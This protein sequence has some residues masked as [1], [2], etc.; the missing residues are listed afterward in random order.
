[1]NIIIKEGSNSEQF[2]ISGL[3]DYSNA[4]FAPLLFELGISMAYLMMRRDNPAVYVKP[5]LQGYLSVIHLSKYAMDVLFY[6]I[7]GR[8]AQSYLNG[9]SLNNDN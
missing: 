9:K 5:F 4:V 3:I 6:V 8:L 1:M 2:N 7:L